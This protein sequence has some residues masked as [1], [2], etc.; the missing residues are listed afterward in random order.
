MQRPPPLVPVSSATWPL[1]PTAMAIDRITSLASLRGMSQQRQPYSAAMLHSLRSQ[2]SL[3]PPRKIRNVMGKPEVRG[4]RPV[5]A[6]VGTA[7]P[8]SILGSAPTLPGRNM[9]GDVGLGSQAVYGRGGNRRESYESQRGG[10]VGWRRQ[11]DSRMWMNREPDAMRKMRDGGSSGGSN[12]NR[13]NKAQTT[14]LLTVGSDM[15]RQI[16]VVRERLDSDVTRKSSDRTQRGGHAAGG[17]CEIDMTKHTSTSFEDDIIYL[18][19]QTLATPTVYRHSSSLCV[20]S[21]GQDR[22]PRLCRMTVREDYRHERRQQDVVQAVRRVEVLSDQRHEQSKDKPQSLIECDKETSVLTSTRNRDELDLLGN[23]EE[24]TRVE[25]VVL[26]TELEKKNKETV[27]TPASTSTHDKTEESE[28]SMGKFLSSTCNQEIARVEEDKRQHIDDSRAETVIQEANRRTSDDVIEGT[29]ID[30]EQKA[31]ASGDD[32]Y[33]DCEDLELKKQLLQQELQK[34]DE[35]EAAADSQQSD[36]WQRQKSRKSSA[37]R[38]SDYQRSRSVPTRR[39]LSNRR[40]KKPRSKSRTSVTSTSNETFADQQYMRER[41][42]RDVAAFLETGTLCMDNTTVTRDTDM[43]TQGGN[44]GDD[45]E[46]RLRQQLLKSMQESNGEDE[47][48][49]LRQQLLKSVQTVSQK[50][51][52]QTSGSTHNVPNKSTQTPSSDL[53]QTLKQSAETQSAV[54]TKT[55]TTALVSKP[56]VKTVTEPRTTVSKLQASPIVKSQSK[57]GSSKPRFLHGQTKRQTTQKINRKNTTL[58]A[59]MVPKKGDFIIEVSANDD[60]DSDVHVEEVEHLQQKEAEKLAMMKFVGMS[61]EE[62][63]KELRKVSDRS[64]TPVAKSARKSATTTTPDSIAHLPK[65]KLEEYKKL[66][67]EI[68]HRERKRKQQDQTKSISKKSKVGAN[69]NQQ[70]ASNVSSLRRQTGAQNFMFRKVGGG[71]RVSVGKGEVVKVQK[72]GSRVSSRMMR[73]MEVAAL[74]TRLVA[75]NTLLS[76]SVDK[77][78][79]LREELKVSLGCGK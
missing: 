16:G 60:S 14:P 48:E 69:R 78:V 57:Q 15:R 26:I 8:A 56:E 45:E 27:V 54:T 23:K 3:E 70:A 36:T 47:E 43:S 37:R 65:D 34:L 35:Q 76:G 61:L 42:E 51:V 75:E 58:K 40:R 49:R 1:T 72:G 52:N 9:S 33:E 53:K 31:I 39:T 77:V 44:G 7:R 79:K 20:K 71:R 32:E 74:C 18:G 22:D 66:R 2:M 30:R 17:T 11:Y 21:G 73:E 10:Y 29:D 59:S 50:T 28:Y 68:L 25:D 5:A 6:L 67:I 4:L 55:T 13:L 12:S 63:L 46:E 64:I 19:Q 41:L 38:I 24:Q 62:K